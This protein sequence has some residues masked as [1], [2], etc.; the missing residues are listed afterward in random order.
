[1]EDFVDTLLKRNG[2]DRSQVDY[3]GVHP[4]SSKII[5][6]V[7]ER[8]DLPEEALDSSRRILFE[9]GNMSSPTVLFV[10]EDIILKQ[11]PSQGDRC[12]MMSFGPG[13]TMEAAL[14]GW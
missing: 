2:L 8:L 1:V 12:V 13:L 9:Y 5:D 10:L 4:G 6:Y 3:W 11:K 7:Q 14:V